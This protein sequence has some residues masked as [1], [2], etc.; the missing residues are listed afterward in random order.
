MA[1][2]NETVDELSL[3]EVQTYVEQTAK[4]L[5]LSLPAAIE[6]QVVENFVRV[7]AIARP[8][9]EFELPDTI[10]PAPTFEP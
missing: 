9:M 1:A 6:P 2:P 7:M 4:L 3:A 5:G 8:V 10:E